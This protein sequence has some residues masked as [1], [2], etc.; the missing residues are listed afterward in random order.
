MIKYVVIY[1]GYPSFLLGR[2]NTLEKAE[3]AVGGNPETWAIYEL[4]EKEDI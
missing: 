2:Y 4:I 3:K 1:V